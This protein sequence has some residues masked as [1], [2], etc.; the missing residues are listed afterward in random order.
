VFFSPASATRQPQD[1]TAGS[2][3]LLAADASVAVARHRLAEELEAQQREIALLARL[4]SQLDADSAGVAALASEHQSVADSLARLDGMMA[5]AEARLR[6]MLGQEI[7]ATRSLA[8]ENAR[9]A[10]SLRTVLAAGVA[11][12]DRE[13]LDAEVAT[14]AAYSRIADMAANGLSN[15]IA[16]HPAFVMRDSV[17]TH[18]LRA[19]TLLGELQGSYGVSRGGLAAALS[20]LRSSDGPAV[21]A[22][23]RALSDAEAR[24]T[25]VEG[26]AIAAATAELS[27]R[28]GE[29]VAALQRGTE[30]ATFGLASATFFRAI[31]STRSVGDAG[32]AARAVG[33]STVTGGGSPARSARP[34]GTMPE[35]RR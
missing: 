24:R 23:R 25:S 26:E 30:A 10:D 3:S 2:Q 35:E 33:A 16:H 22:A 11:P 14:A 31:D 20:A 6:A 1:V 4:A 29:L 12:Q 9:T 34:R 32:A 15:A 5:A 28:A 18:G 17:R 27:A 19:R 8:A 7:D 21:S 13:A